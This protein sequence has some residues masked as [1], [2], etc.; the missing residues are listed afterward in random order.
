[1]QGRD[2]IIA[3]ISLSKRVSHN[4]VMAMADAWS[5]QSAEDVC[6]A[7]DV[8]HRP[9][10]YF[11]DV[12]QLSPLTT[13]IVAIVDEATDESVLGW[14]SMGLAPYGR[15]C[16]NP[17]LDNGGCVLFDVNDP[18]RTAVAGVGSHEAPIELTTDP[19]CN[20]YARDADGNEWDMEH[21]DPVQRNQYFRRVQMPWGS[22]LVALSDF[23]RPAW[24]RP[25]AEPSG[26]Y[27]FL[28]SEFP[29]AGPFSIAP[30]GYAIRNG[31][32]VWPRRADGSKIL[33]PAWWLAMRPPGSHRANRRR[34]RRIWSP[35]E[36]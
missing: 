6:P 23:V 11:R 3:V 16:V 33:P 5:R 25:G 28:S 10:N 20:F 7:W 2:D 13:D 27:N 29:M 30:G 15:V 24:Y 19:E 8:P 36:A 35:L 31:G 12:G 26:R 22:E 21:A 4:Q 14:H 9:I 17:I 1:M 32:A 18:Q 34:N